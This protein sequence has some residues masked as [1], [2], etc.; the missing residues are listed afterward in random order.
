VAVLKR[1]YETQTCSIAR[2]LEVVGERWSMLILRSVFL[3]VHRFDDLRGALGITRSVLTTRLERL[4]D[5]GVLKRVPYQERPPRHEYR[6]T[7]K[8][9]ELFPVVLHLLR[10]G[11][12]HYPEPAGAPRVVEHA[13]CGGR[14]DDHLLCER[15]GEPLTYFNTASRPGPGARATA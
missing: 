14:P 15:C 4:V 5:E 7:A 12:A 13:G 3:G 9:G 10:W 1:E 2:S 11:D 6:A 8:G